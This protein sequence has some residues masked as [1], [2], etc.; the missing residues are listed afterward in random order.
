MFH[1]G[2]HF[3]RPA[4]RIEMKTPIQK[5][6]TI[7]PERKAEMVETIRKIAEELRI[8]GWLC[9]PSDLEY[10]AGRIAEFEE[11]QYTKKSESTA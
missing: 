10:Q 9:I 2:L 8:G 6:P 1:Q 11:W 4:E 5:V 3:I 7:S